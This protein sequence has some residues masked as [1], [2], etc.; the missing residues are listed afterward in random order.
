MSMYS[1]YIKE[2]GV[3]RI[4]ERASGFMSY[5]FLDKECYLMDIYV[6]SEF[7]RTGLSKELLKAVTEDAKL[8]NYNFL[9]GAVIHNFKYKDR[10]KAMLKSWGFHFLKEDERVTWY[11]KNISEETK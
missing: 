4:V 11:I 2:T 6:K 9:T 10:S 8:N 3:Y 7:R 1:D 5:V